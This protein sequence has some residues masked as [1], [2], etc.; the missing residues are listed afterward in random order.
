MGM[1]Y[2]LQSLIA[3]MMVVLALVYGMYNFQLKPK[4]R[5]INNLKSS[6]K[7]IDSEI[8]TI[9]GGEMLL[10]DIGAARASVQKELAEISL[11]VPAE[12]ESPYLI[13]NFISVVGKGLNIDYGLIQP[14]EI[15]PEDRYKILPMTVEFQGDYANLNLYLLQLR[16]LPMTIRVDSMILHKL[17]DNN[18]LA[19][20]MLLSAFV[21]PG[22]TQRPDEKARIIRRYYDPFYTVN[23]KSEGSQLEGVA[24]LKYTGYWIGKKVQAIINDEVL[25]VGDSIKGYKV[26]QIGKDKV[27]VEKSGKKYE[28]P[29]A[30]N[31]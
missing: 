25:K 5:E 13:N 24:G 8:R 10:K 26:L 23:A 11:K 1:S 7:L 30:K 27:V 21:M 15:A 2:R 31:R 16:R 28:L 6:L 9:E 12:V 18:K 22:G 4:I 19:V 3:G 29:L 20:R 17:M 14:G